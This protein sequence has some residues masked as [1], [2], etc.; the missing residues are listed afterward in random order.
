MDFAAS[1]GWLAVCLRA[2]QLVQMCVQARWASDSSLLILPHLQESHLPLLD[3]A[4][5][6]V[7]GCGLQEI[8]CLP[9]LLAA[10]EHN[11]QFLQHAL[12]KFLSS[13]HI[14]EVNVM[15]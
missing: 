10:C 9:E 15:T 2:M 4:G 1:E 6:G 11:N 8:S 3:R 5:G 7:R 13:Q 14:T 12:L